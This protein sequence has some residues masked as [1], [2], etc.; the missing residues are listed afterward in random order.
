[1]ELL[2]H[3]S[4]GGERQQRGDAR[5][6]DGVLQLALVQRA[7]AGDAARKDLAALG[8]ELLERLHVLEVDVLDL[9]DAELADA[10]A[11]VEELLLAALLAARTATA[12]VAAG[13][14]RTARSSS[15]RCHRCHLRLLLYACGA[16][17]S[18]PAVM[19]LSTPG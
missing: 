7:G 1:M 8:D 13:A 11:A 3:A 18:A 12:I 10:L 19:T 6:L 15:S 5:A 17:S 16:A 9:L 14:T 4:I 2:K